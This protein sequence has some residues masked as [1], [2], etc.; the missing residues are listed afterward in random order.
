MAGRGFYVNFKVPE[1]EQVLRNMS[2]YDAKTALKVEG[3]VHD[4]TKAIKN[5]AVRRIHNESGY[6]KKHTNYSFNK[7][8]ITGA[9]R[10]K[11]PHAHLVEFGA[12]AVVEK[13]KKKKAL[14]VDQFGNRNYA[15]KVNIPIRK[16]HPFMRPS[17][18]DEKPNMIRGLKEA[19]QP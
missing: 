19:V 11:A 14:T 18:E 16:E 8:T 17:Y 13:P 5:G 15:K 9:I 4:S 2:K 6:L 7:K 12:K 3:V 1:I 10:A